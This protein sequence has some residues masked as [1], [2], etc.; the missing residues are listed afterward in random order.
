VSAAARYHFSILV[1]S[2]GCRI[3]QNRRLLRFTTEQAGEGLYYIC[4]SKP[5]PGAALAAAAVGVA[6]P[7]LSVQQRVQLWH[8]P[9][10]LRNY[11][12]AWARTAPCCH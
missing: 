3:F 12:P 2:M 9:V 1:D 10:G 6:T 7:A 5:K 11:A 8:R 4:S